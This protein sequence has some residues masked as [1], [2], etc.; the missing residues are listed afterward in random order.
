MKKTSF[1]TLEKAR[2]IIQDI[3]KEKESVVDKLKNQPSSPNKDAP[4]KK[5]KEEIR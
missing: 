1:L 5:H 2:R 4:A 3:P